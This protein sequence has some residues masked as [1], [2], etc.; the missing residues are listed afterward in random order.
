MD[1]RK[2]APEWLPRVEAAVSKL[3]DASDDDRQAACELVEDNW[4]PLARAKAQELF[5]R[6]HIA[7]DRTRLTDLSARLAK[8]KPSFILPK[9]RNKS[10][11][12]V[13]EPKKLAAEPESE[14]AC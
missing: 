8:V 10:L 4:G 13:E 2:V 3:A 9:D 1:E 6:Q 7:R 11:D 12:A 5:E 14:R